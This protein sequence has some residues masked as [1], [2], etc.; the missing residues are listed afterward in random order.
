MVYL[1]DLLFNVNVKYVRVRNGRLSGNTGQTGRSTHLCG[2]PSYTKTHSSLPGIKMYTNQ[3]AGQRELFM[4]PYF[5]LFIRFF[6]FFCQDANK[7]KSNRAII[8]YNF[9]KKHKLTL[10]KTQSGE[11]NYVDYKFELAT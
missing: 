2:E 1:H 10:Y 5:Y 3:R 4:D 6:S 9:S 7:T 8:G 11:L